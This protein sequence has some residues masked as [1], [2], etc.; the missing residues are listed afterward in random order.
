MEPV[1]KQRNKQH[2]KDIDLDLDDDP[3]KDPFLYL[4][5]QMDE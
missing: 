3:A 4:I 1:Q 5:K 2:G